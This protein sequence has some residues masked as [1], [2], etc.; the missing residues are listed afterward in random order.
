[1]QRNIDDMIEKKGTGDV[2][3][4][5]VEDSLYPVWFR[6]MYLPTHRNAERW[7][8]FLLTTHSVDCVAGCGCCGWNT[9]KISAAR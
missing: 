9:A 2:H 4:E 1:M 8:D 5:A 6:K 7:L 3:V